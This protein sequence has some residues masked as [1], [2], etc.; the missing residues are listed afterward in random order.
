MVILINKDKRYVF[1]NI[2]A[3]AMKKLDMRTQYE[4]SMMSML[5]IM[6]GMIVMG[7]YILFFT[8]FATFMKVMVVVNTLAGFT[9]LSS[10]LVTTYQQYITY[11]DFHTDYKEDKK[12]LKV[13]INKK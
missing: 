6:I 3:E 9:F 10:Y 11:L 2:M 8:E 5:T 1:P 12:W 4:A 7:V 13:K